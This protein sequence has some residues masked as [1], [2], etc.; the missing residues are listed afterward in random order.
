MVRTS[1]P[2]TGMKIESLDPTL[3]DR[4]STSSGAY[5]RAHALAKST[6]Q[7]LSLGDVAFCLRQSIAVVHVADIALKVTEAQPF[8]E[9][10]LYAGDLLVSLLTAA[11]K[12]TLNASQLA[13]LESV[14][15]GALAAFDGLSDTV[16]PAVA[17]FLSVVGRR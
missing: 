8:V 13:A 12:S 6:L 9:A 1:T 11:D 17:R 10:E 15:D 14:C 3:A 5:D 16:L 7:E 4:P 2:P